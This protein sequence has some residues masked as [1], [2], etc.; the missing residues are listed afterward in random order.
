MKLAPEKIC[1]GLTEEL[2]RQSLATFLQLSG[3]KDFA[4]LFSSRLSSEE[5]N[6]YI[7]H[8]TDLLKKHINQNEYH[9]FFLG[10][11][12]HHGHKE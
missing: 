1:F 9:Q 2:D 12:H 7:D 11:S 3:N 8:F 4:E 5:I 6:H 10:E